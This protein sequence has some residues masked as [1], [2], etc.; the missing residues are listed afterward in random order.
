MN[1][2]QRSI[3]IIWLTMASFGIVGNA[4]GSV[5]PPKKT[6]GTATLKVMFWKIYT[7]TLL[8]PSGDF[9]SDSA[10]Y[11][12]Q[13]HY[14]RD[15]SQQQLI[16]AT[17]KQWQH[18]GV[19]KSKYSTW[20]PL[21]ENIWPDINKGDRLTLQV[22]PTMSTFILNGDVIGTVEDSQFGSTFSDIWLSE[23]SQY[24]RLQRQLIGKNK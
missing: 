23:Q 20:L 1:L 4:L 24:P 7:A 6:V 18:L 11:S 9:G 17:V 2:G 22:T 10:N 16:E 14:A 8:T 21:L 13:L 3:L 15:I 19:N 12:L 5:N